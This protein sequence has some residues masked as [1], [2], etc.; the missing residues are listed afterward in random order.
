M[1]VIP[2]FSYSPGERAFLAEDTGSAK[3]QDVRQRSEIDQGARQ[4][5]GDEVGLG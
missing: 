5:M 2:V 4:V 1:T 3:A